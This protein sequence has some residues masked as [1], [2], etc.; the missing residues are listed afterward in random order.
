MADDPKPVLRYSEF[1]FY[2]PMLDSQ[3]MRISVSDGKTGEYFAIVPVVT[4][5]AFRNL[6]MTALNAIESAIDSGLYPGQVP[7]PGVP[8]AVIER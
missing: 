4:G 2:S 7:V 6:R 3:A 5:K 1:T 8:S